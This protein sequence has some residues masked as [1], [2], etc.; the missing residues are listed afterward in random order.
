LVIFYPNLVFLAVT[1]EPEMLRSYQRLKRL[2][3]QST[4]Y[5][6]LESKN[7]L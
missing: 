3:L 2:R 5:G 7:S 6:K 1:F 4:F